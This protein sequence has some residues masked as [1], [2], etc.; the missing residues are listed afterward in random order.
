MKINKVRTS[1]MSKLRASM[2]MNVFAEEPNAESSNGSEEEVKTPETKPEQEV[3]KPQ[4]TVNF[5]D[6]VKKAREEEK[7]KL[8][9]QIEK[10]KKDKNDLLLV[11]AEKDK[12]IKDLEKEITELQKNHSKLAKDV[13][14]STSTNKVVQEQAL[15]ISQLEQQLED[16]Q[17]QYEL[18]VNSL[19][20]NSYREKQIA[21]AGGAIIPELVTGNTEEEINASIELA[22]QRYAQIQEQAM[23]S[24][25]MPKSVNP[26]VATLSQTAMKSVEDIASMTPAEWAEYRKN[27]NIK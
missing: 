4:G 8:Y 25:Q 9:P 23:S 24:V 12:A 19:K 7:S 17:A 5:E 21:L 22:K 18:D 20:I 10:L 16:I 14:E 11:V 26:S 6:L 13:E 3:P 1:F 2:F 15:L 27:L